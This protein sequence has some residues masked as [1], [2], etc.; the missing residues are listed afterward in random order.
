MSDTTARDDQKTPPN[1]EGTDANNNNNNDGKNDGDD[2]NDDDDDDDDFFLRMRVGMCF[3]V[4]SVHQLLQMFGF[5]QPNH[6]RSS[7]T[8]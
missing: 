5:G 7:L 2:N 8:R 3:C 1:I 6:V 4:L